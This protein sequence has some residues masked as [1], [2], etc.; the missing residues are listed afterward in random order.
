MTNA[1]LF[2]AAACVQFTIALGEID[3][4]IEQVEQLINSCQ[5]AANTLLLLPEL[6]ATG[7]DYAR[8]AE[9]GAR[10]PEILSCMQRTAA[11]YQVYL[12]GT[13]TALPGNEGLPC[14]MLYLVGPDG[15]IGRRAK[16][17]LFAFWQEDQ[18]YQ[19]GQAAPLLQTPQGPLGTL[20]CYDLRFPE[21]ARRQVFAGC[22]I[23]AVSAQWPLVRLDHWQALLRARA[24]ENQS[25]VVAANSC[26]R[27]GPMELA[28][29]S[30][31][32][33]PDGTDLC[34][35]GTTA[36]V[37]SC[38]LDNSAVDA[39]RSRFYP[40]GRRAWLSADKG[41]IKTLD[42]LLSELALIRRDKSCIAF[43]NGCFDILHPGHVSYLEKA[44]SSA[45]CLVVGV[46]TDVSVRALK[47]PDRPINSEQDRARVLAALG[48]VDYVVLFAQETP[49]NLITAIMPDVLVKGAD[50]AEE[51]IVGAA[52]VKA[53]GGRLLRIPFT[54]DRSTTTL[55]DRIRTAVSGYPSEQPVSLQG[56][57]HMT[58]VQIQGMSCQH[59]AAAAQKVLQ[60]LGA[61][62]V[63]VD[64]A[65]GE[66]RFEGTVDQ[67]ALRQAMAAQGYE[68]VTERL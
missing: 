27:T 16:Q 52:E 4:N 35:A 44:R 12:A 5:P 15:V 1:S 34:T 2:P 53:Q 37:I 3:K 7:F 14:N 68:V 25:Y 10:T 50:W 58:T 55:I 63:Q 33:G 36:T 43:T 42:E 19:G 64:V 38:R 51:D 8:T 48:C 20:I 40:A 46:N 47:G 17:H 57:P 11:R 23:L 21:L 26:G 18:H 67:E 60:E 30:M 24:I 62:M 39:Q 13:L 32:I 9:L 41:K 66:A 61:T 28:G 45:D 65:S 29:H 59:C 49:I 31:I 22:R 54:H 56:E 6:W